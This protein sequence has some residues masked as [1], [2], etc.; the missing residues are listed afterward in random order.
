MNLTD[1]KTATALDVIKR[2]QNEVENAK[3]S[4]KQM[5]EDVKMMRFKI[6]PVFGDIAILAKKDIGFLEALWK[7]GKME[8][9][10]NHEIIKLNTVEKE[11]FFHYWQNKHQLTNKASFNLSN[12]P[13]DDKQHAAVLEIEVV[14]TD[15]VRK[16]ILN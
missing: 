11:I 5:L 9:I 15:A 3:P 6:R 7:I 2:V 16:N 10:I 12:K 8:E 14:K 13:I 1:K 4:H